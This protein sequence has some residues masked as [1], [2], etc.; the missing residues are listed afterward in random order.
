MAVRAWL[1]QGVIHSRL[2]PSNILEH[3]GCLRRR[4]CVIDWGLCATVDLLTRPEGTHE[5]LFH[6]ARC[7]LPH[8]TPQEGRVVG[9][10]QLNA[11]GTGARRSDWSARGRY[12]PRRS[13]VTRAQWPFI[14]V[15]HA[16]HEQRH[17]PQA[18]LGVT[19]AAVPDCPA[20]AIRPRDRSSTR[21]MAREPSAPLF[22]EQEA[23]GGYSTSI[24][25]GRLVTAHSYTLAKDHTPWMRTTSRPRRT[26]VCLR[27]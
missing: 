6:A 8:C 7:A 17:A 10:S 15:R 9:D 25:A 18:S 22:E 27:D 11:A 13:H 2:K 14:Y 1:V 21:A 19:C 12:A 26:S 4:R 23:G 16:S 24:T 5:E 3:C 20:C